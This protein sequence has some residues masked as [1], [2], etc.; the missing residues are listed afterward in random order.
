[1]TGAQ[2]ASQDQT[3]F[4]WTFISDYYKIN[5]GDKNY[6][7]FWTRLR[8]KWF[9]LY[10]EHEVCFPDKEVDD[11]LPD[12]QARVTEDIQARIKQLKTWF[13]W[14]VNPRASTGGRRGR[15]ADLE[16]FEERT[17]QLKDYEMYSKLYYDEKIKPL[18]EEV[19]NELG[20]MELSKGEKLN[21]RKR[22]ARD[23]YEGEDEDVKELVNAKLK[24]RAKVME[25]RK[26]DDV[27]R[28]P[29]QYLR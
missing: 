18:V 23:L 14:R 27:D 4:L 13:R 10:P 28:T 5:K 11:V 17:R 26:N 9:E 12:E 8:E 1:M 29:E 7:P 20:S 25:D 16:P 21:L 19:E 22:I 15:L 6:V 3:E 2:W 24:E